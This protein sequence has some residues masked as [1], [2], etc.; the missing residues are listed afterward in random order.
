MLNIIN[1][2]LTFTIEDFITQKLLFSKLI[3]AD[4]YEAIYKT[5]YKRVKNSQTTNQLHQ[6][7][8][9][10]IK[11]KDPKRDRVKNDILDAYNQECNIFT[12]TAPTGIGKTLTSLEL[13]LKIKEDKRLE[14]IIYIL[15]FT[16]IIDQ[17][18][19]I[20][21]KLFSPSDNQT[22]LRSHL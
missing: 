20:F 19:E 3:F 21:D 7:L 9:E 15:P 11:T 12:L 10:I 5:H 4:K 13:A 2:D 16:S 8:N 22:A 1:R 17:T 14:K 18:Y 6:A